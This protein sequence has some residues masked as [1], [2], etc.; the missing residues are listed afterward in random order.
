MRMTECNAGNDRYAVTLRLMLCFVNTS[1]HYDLAGSI[2]LLVVG[3]ISTKSY[4]HICTCYHK[5]ESL[6]SQ[7]EAYYI[8]RQK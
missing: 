7:L 2:F 1:G 8:P 4:L 6:V 3:S 5:E